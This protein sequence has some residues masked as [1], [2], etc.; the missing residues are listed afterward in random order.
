MTFNQLFH[1]RNLPCTAL[2]GVMIGQGLAGWLVAL[3]P[4]SAP[5]MPYNTAVAQIF[6]QTD[7]APATLVAY[8]TWIFAVM[9]GTLT[10]W[11]VACA[12]LAAIPL[13]RGEKWAGHAIWTSLAVWF[14]VDTG[15][16][17]HLGVWPNVALN[18]A[19]LAVIVAA[20]AWAWPKGALA[21]QNQ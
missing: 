2:T 7:V 16:S 18:C 17:A 4:D 5:L 11:S 19:A 21:Q 15:I 12:W 14:P 10:A 8:R 9:G 6:W 20:L 3:C 1:R 13:R